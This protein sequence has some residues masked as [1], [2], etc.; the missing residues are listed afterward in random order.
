[1]DE[2]LIIVGEGDQKENKER[3]INPLS[4]LLSHLS[5]APACRTCKL[6]LLQTTIVQGN[7]LSIGH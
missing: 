3:R 1:M 6:H 2:E 5:L 4:F 7:K